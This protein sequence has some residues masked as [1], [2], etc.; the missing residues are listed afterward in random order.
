MRRS[1]GMQLAVLFMLTFTMLIIGIL[2]DLNNFCHKKILIIFVS[3][4]VCVLCVYILI[5][6]ISNIF[7]FH[8]PLF[9]CIFMRLRLSF[10]AKLTKMVAKSGKFRLKKYFFEKKK[11][12]KILQFFSPPNRSANIYCARSRLSRNNAHTNRITSNNTNI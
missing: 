2:N 9:Y 7:I 11:S 5:L 12:T 3:G 8:L 6:G 10:S 1:C 4:C